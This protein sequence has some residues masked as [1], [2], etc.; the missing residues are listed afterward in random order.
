MLDFYKG[1][2]LVYSFT[3]TAVLAAIGDKPGY[4][5]N[6][7]PPFLG[8]NGGQPYAFVNI[9]FTDGDS[10]DRVVFHQTTN[11]GY[12]S[13]NHTVGYW[14]EQGGI[15]VPEPATWAMLISGFGLV[16]FTARRRNA[17]VSQ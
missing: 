11:A 16:G 5:G 1:G 6:P 4:F 12:E 2:E 10:F 9:Y 14:I 7:N 17:A 8:A 3:P 15:G 13:D